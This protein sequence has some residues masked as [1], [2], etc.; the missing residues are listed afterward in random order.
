MK[1]Q[2]MRITPSSDRTTLQ[3]LLAGWLIVLQVLSPALYA[4]NAWAQ[5]TSAAAINPDRSVAGERP[6]VNVAANGVPIVQIAP[7]SAAGVSN[8]RFTDYNVGSKGAILNNSGANNQTQLGGWIS[9]NPM[10]GNSSAKTIL[11]QVTGSTPSS[12]TG[13]TEVAGNRA[14][15]IVANPNG[16][17]CDGCGF[18][19]APRATL[20]TGTPQLGADGAVLGFQVQQGQINIEGQGLAARNV[21]QVDLIARTLRVNAE[22]WAGKLN[23]VTG[24]A[25]VNY[26]GGDAVAHSASDAAPAVSLDVAQLGGM[27]ADSIRLVGTESGVGVNSAGTIAALMGTLEIN[28]AGDVRIVAGRVQAAGDLT[29]RSGQGVSNAG[30]M[31]A[32]GKATI[33]AQGTL[34][35]NGILMAGKDMQSRVADLQNSG[36]IAAGANADGKITA[37]N[38]VSIA[39]SGKLQNSGQIQAGNNLTLAG[40]KTVLDNDR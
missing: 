34:Q 36:S 14:N 25:E 5:P 35:N 21:D 7:P 11:N 30:V 37:R 22:I 17:T 10:L 39:A 23:V 18:I 6:V 2:T 9:G 31:Y 3:R 12:L 33:Q 1:E 27:Y 13:F 26:D 4:G 20:T 29:I 15:V 28:Q 32:E 24:A 16:I 40:G 19:N 8:N 38:D